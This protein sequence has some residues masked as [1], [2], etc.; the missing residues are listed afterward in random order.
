[1]SATSKV[2]ESLVSKRLR[3]HV[4]VFLPK[5]NLVFAKDT[6]LLYKWLAYRINLLNTSKTA[7]L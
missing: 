4:D 7:T 2:V 5:T 3:K 1:M 6:V